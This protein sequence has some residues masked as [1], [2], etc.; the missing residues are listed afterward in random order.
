MKTFIELLHDIR[1]DITEET[2]DMS[3]DQR[4]SYENAVL[5]KYLEKT[6]QQDR[7]IHKKEPELVHSES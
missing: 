5:E 3:P 7:V 1:A 6:D 4:T 2:K